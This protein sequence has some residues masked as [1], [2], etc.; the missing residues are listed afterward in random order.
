MRRL[1]R[2][3]IRDV[4]NNMFTFNSFKYRYTGT[5]VDNYFKTQQCKDIYIYVNIYNKVIRYLFDSL[6]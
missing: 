2:V 4:Q 6:L 1:Q 3:H 5:N